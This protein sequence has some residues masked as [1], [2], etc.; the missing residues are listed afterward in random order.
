MLLLAAPA[1]AQEPTPTPQVVTLES[2]QTFTYTPEI[3]I[4]EA[5]II[6]AVLFLAGV[7]LLSLIQHVSE[8]L[9]R[10]R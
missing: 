3:T 7:Q 10:W 2:G 5:G 9:T 8:W 4:G 6:L 1:A